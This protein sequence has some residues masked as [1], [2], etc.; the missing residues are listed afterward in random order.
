MG[1]YPA[2]ILAGDKRSEYGAAGATA[3]QAGQ[4]HAMIQDSRESLGQHLQTAEEILANTDDDLH[5][6]RLAA[7]DGND[8]GKDFF[9]NLP[10]PSTLDPGGLTEERKQFF[11]LVQEQ[12]GPRRDGLSRTPGQPVDRTGR[13]DGIPESG[14]GAGP[15]RLWGLV[16]DK[17][18]RQERL[19]RA[20][21]IYPFDDER[22][23]T[24]R[25]DAD[26]FEGHT[27][28]FEHRREPGIDER[29]FACAR[30]AEQHDQAVEQDL[31]KHGFDLSFASEEKT[32][33]G[34]VEGNY[35]PKRGRR[36][37]PGGGCRVH[38]FP[39]FP[40][41]CNS[42]TKSQRST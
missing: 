29:R 10:F 31:R 17:D 22:L 27:A 5:A 25:P 16:R 1:R 7:R 19:I 14:H 32:R 15:L 20:A 39:P 41:R 28:A 18:A 13:F 21:R 3:V 30:F 35:A 24:V 36:C 37:L 6:E 2:L 33:G 4:P 38:Y 12:H 26:T 8:Q 9:L 34:L 40:R 42:G 23:L 11:E